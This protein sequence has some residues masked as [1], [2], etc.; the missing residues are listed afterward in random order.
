MEYFCLFY[1]LIFSSK[2]TEEKSLLA[3]QLNLE[4]EN[5]SA[6]EDAKNRLVTREQ[7]LRDTLND[8]EARLESEREKM[9]TVQ[10]ERQKLIDS[11]QNLE[12]Q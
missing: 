9:Y 6:L 5:C 11:V 4:S 1:N 10:N 12:D 7:E 2:L 8:L 3:E